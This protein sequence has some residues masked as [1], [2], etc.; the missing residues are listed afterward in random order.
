MNNI[1]AEFVT[2]TSKKTGKQFEALQF[3]VLTDGGEYKS[4]LSFPSNLEKDLI[5]KAINP[6]REIYG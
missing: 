1:K 3:T 2:L 5:K 6:M 4:G